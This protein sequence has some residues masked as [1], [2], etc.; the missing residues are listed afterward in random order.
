VSLGINEVRTTTRFLLPNSRVGWTATDQSQVANCS[1]AGIELPCRSR[2]AAA[3]S[4][5]RTVYLPQRAGVTQGTNI[6]HP[7]R[8]YANRPDRPVTLLLTS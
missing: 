3:D 7:V 5:Q 8:H 6:A 2:P 4:R 1:S